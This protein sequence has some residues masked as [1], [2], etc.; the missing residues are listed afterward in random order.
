[1][2]DEIWDKLS[3]ILNDFLYMMTMTEPVK[4]RNGF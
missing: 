1:M 4:L 3:K 2:V